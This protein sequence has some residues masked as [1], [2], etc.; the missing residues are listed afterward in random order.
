LNSFIRY[1]CESEEIE[2]SQEVSAE[3]GIGDAGPRPQT[4]VAYA[5]SASAEAGHRGED[6]S[7]PE[8]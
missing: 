3:P 4:K 7:P 5:A 8:V 6:H 1:A 2:Q